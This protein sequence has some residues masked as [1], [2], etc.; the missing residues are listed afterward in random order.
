MAI[1]LTAEEMA[2]KSA[3]IGLKNT[4]DQAEDQGKKLHLTKIELATHKQ[5]LLDLKAEV[6]K[7]KAVA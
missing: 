3:K 5:L 2:R 4:Q 7:A 6:E 1:K